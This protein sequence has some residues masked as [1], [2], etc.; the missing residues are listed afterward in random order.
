MFLD[1]SKLKSVKSVSTT[2]RMAVV[3]NTI[4]PALLKKEKAV[5]SNRNNLFLVK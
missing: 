4:T 1:L 5:R 3:S 2:A